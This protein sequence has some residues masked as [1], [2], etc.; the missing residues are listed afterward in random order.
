MNQGDRERLELA[1]RV[2][3]AD[4][5]SG[6]ELEAGVRRV[7]RAM[8][9]HRRADPAKRVVSL[10][11]AALALCAALAYGATGGGFRL[12]GPAEPS[13]SEAPSYL[14][15]GARATARRAHTLSHAT[16]LE[17]AKTREQ[18]PV[19]VLES[20]ALEV[21]A[22]AR[23]AAEK[24]AGSS[25]ASASSSS[26]GAPS[27]AAAPG[28]KP[29]AAARKPGAARSATSAEPAANSWREV[30]AALEAEDES[31]A[32]T[33]LRDLATDAPDASTRAKAQLGLA[34]LAVSRGEC[35]R[36]SAIALRV[37]RTPGVDEKL[38]DRAHNLVMRCE[39]R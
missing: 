8:R 22:D 6:T 19:P 29:R 18:V 7:T 32:R 4:Q 20:E 23:D 2:W 1:Y 24:P 27:G 21:D 26:S 30:G 15:K 36:A 38:V 10:G 16:R 39:R 17:G 31:R 12:A 37:A 14:S 9:G 3:H 28:G 5:L 11:A 34:Q 13:A 33:L 25:A 35:N